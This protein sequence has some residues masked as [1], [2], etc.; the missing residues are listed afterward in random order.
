MNYKS[1]LHRN[2]SKVKKGYNKVFTINGRLTW[3]GGAYY[4]RT[5][6]VFVETLFIDRFDDYIRIDLRAQWT[7]SKEKVTSV[8][9]IDLQN[10]LGRENQA[11]V[12]YDF[13]LD[14]METS[15]NLGLIPVLTYRLEF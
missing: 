6:G 2:P 9:A 3:Q 5:D 7:K 1:W 12:Y 8:W 10:A 15:T 11:F 14:R 13:F 4:N